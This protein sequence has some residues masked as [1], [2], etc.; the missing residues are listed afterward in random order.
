MTSLPLLVT[1]FFFLSI[2]CSKEDGPCVTCPPAS[3]DTTSHNFSWTTTL[4]GDGGGSVLSDV[5]IVN[6]TLAY[7]VGGI[8]SKDSMGNFDPNSYNLLMWDG[9][10]WTPVRIQFFTICGQVSRTAYPASGV[11]AFS[12]TDI[13]IAMHGDQVARWNGN[14]QTATMC[15]PISFSLK[16]I[17]GE[18]STSVYAV[19]D[20]G[21][22]VH[23]N[24][25]SWQSLASGT[26]LDLRDIWGAVDRC[27]GEQQILAVG[28]RNNPLDR[29]ILRIQGSSVTPVSTAQIPYELFGVWFVPNQR[30]F[31][32]GDGIFE[33]NDLSENA[34]RKVPPDITMFATTAIRGNALN[35]AVI[36]GAFGE[37]LHYNGSTWQSFRSQT[38]I[39]DGAYTS[40][41]MKGNLIIAVGGSGAQAIAVVGRR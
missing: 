35:D 22:I 29:T 16:K 14:V 18:N 15:L 31:V 33:K 38:S 17:W 37:V 4:L 20:G 1:V 8:Y 40:V 25:S 28:T 39:A 6:D 34:W 27:T 24:G 9:A 13:W 21:N 7:A 2:S 11:F 5:V 19:G 23:F 30:Y 26:R 12:S 36:V 32:V 3:V 41:A 10:V